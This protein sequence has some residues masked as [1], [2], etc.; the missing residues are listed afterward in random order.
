MVLPLGQE[1]RD[2]YRSMPERWKLDPP[3]LTERDEAFCYS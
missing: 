2:V 1:V 3:R